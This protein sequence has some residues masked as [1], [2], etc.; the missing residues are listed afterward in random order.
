MGDYPGLSGWGRY[1][2]TGPYKR[3]AQRR[4]GRT[5]TVVTEAEIRGK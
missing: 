4:R 2:D 1:G 5:G 3:T